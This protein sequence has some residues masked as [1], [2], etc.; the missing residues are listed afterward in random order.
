MQQNI[1]SVPFTVEYSL[2][3]VLLSYRLLRSSERVSRAE[4]WKI[5]E[6]T[7][8]AGQ[9]MWSDAWGKTMVEDYSCLRIHSSLRL[10][11]RAL[12]MHGGRLASD[13]QVPE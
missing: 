10:P 7:V 9:F 6:G 13:T 8:T 5:L 4:G 11:W 1:R 3:A 2:V 12:A